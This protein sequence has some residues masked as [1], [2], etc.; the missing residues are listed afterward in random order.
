MTYP[1]R[2]S[3]HRP[4]RT[5]AARLWAFSLRELGRRPGV[6][7]TYTRVVSAPEGGM[8]LPTIGVPAGAPVALD[9][10]FE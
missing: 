6:M 4:A 9:L 8:G 3:T 5:E 7:R 10:R 1:G 2:V